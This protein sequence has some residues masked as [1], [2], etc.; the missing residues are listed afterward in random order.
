MDTVILVI[1]LIGVVAFAISGAVVAI[2]KETDMIGVLFLSHITTFGGGIM[3]DIILGRVPAYFT[4]M[5]PYLIICTITSFLVFLL[6]RLF[7]KWYVVNKR[8]VLDINNYID[9][10]GLGAF[11][12]SSV[13]LALELHPEAG[14][15]L[16]IMMGVITS[17]GG[18]MVRDVCMQDVPFVFRKR[19]Y[20]LAAA[21]GAGAYYVIAV[22]LMPTELGE[23]VASIV[24]MLSV[25]L[26][27]VLATVF[28]LNMPKAIR[29][30]EQLEIAHEI[31]VEETSKDFETGKIK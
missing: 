17:I 8:R 7:K 25:F 3:R 1:E 19:I 23:V 9:A 11:A 18:G 29:F 2:D 26:I 13:K 6:A 15:F 27:R 24:G 21:A 30:S 20:A 10:A 28:R 14:A 16:A 12:V 31:E 22:Y 4:S 5:W